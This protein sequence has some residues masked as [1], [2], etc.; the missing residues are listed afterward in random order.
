MLNRIT[1]AVRKLAVL[2]TSKTTSAGGEFKTIDISIEENAFLNQ[3]H[4]NKNSL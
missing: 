3:L 1:V 4:N 2:K